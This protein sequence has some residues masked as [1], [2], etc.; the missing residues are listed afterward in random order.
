[1][2]KEIKMEKDEIKYI[3]KIEILYLGK[4]K[5]YKSEGLYILLSFVELMDK[6][7]QL[8]LNKENFSEKVNCSI[9]AIERWLKIFVGDN[10]IT[11]KKI[12]HPRPASNTIIITIDCLKNHPTTQ[13]AAGMA[14]LWNSIFR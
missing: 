7:L 9:R 8:S 13:R 6:N 5:K 11:C 1:M 3:L 4:Q 2:S 12:S 10:I 14:T